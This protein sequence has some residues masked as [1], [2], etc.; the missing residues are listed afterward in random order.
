MKISYL[1][2]RIKV[3]FPDNWIQETLLQP[4]NIIVIGF[5]FRLRSAYTER[6]RKR[7][8]AAFAKEWSK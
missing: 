8:L 4:E 1:N 3:A 5:E 7:D 2:Q 6:D